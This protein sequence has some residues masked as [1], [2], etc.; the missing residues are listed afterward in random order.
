MVRSATVSSGEKPPT[1]KKNKSIKNK[2]YY[3]EMLKQMGFNNMRI[4]NKAAKVLDDIYAHIVMDYGKEA[5][6]VTHKVNRVR[7]TSLIVKD[8]MKGRYMGNTY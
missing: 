1:H 6:N 7:T 2:I 3:K 8:I 4:S 5:V